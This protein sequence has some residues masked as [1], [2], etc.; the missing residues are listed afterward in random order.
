M[1]EINLNPSKT[2]W[3]SGCVQPPTDTDGDGVPD[4][5]DNC[6]LVPNPDQANTDAG[7]TAQQRPG[8]DALGDACDPDI[9]GDGY[10]SANKIALGKNPYAYCPPMRADIDGDHA[11]S[12]L[13]L[14]DMAQ[15]FGQS[16]PPAPERDNQDADSAISVLDMATLASQF[17]QDI[18]SCQ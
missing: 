2:F 9:S 13:D 10:G 1:L 8:A 3:V 7:N 5:V 11:V 18:S 4:S 16:V 14:T 12:I 17:G 6:L 15:Y